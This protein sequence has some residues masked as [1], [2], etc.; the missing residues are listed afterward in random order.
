MIKSILTDLWEGNIFPAE[1]LAPDTP[2]FQSLIQKLHEETAYLKSILSADDRKRMEHLEE[3]T[4]S[5][6]YIYHT[7]AFIKG[8]KIAVKM[9]AEVYS[10][11]GELPDI[12]KL[13]GIDEPEKS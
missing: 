10:D 13:L 7:Q 9:M 11:K 3:L 8:F 12:Q 6:S 4:D 2:E 1:N 5:L